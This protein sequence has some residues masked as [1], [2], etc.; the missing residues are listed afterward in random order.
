MSEQRRKF[1]KEYKS[2]AFEFANKIGYSKAARE[3]GINVNNITRW[4]DLPTGQEAE[5][6]KSMRDLEKENAEL[7]K[8]IGYLKI[9]NDVLK[10]STAILSQDQIKNS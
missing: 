6:L 8:E 4:R 3:L 9:I 1:S 5:R 7:R 2:E 10:K